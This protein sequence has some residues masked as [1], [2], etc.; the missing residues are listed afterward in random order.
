MSFS[1]A[2]S[3]VLFV[4]LTAEARQPFEPVSTAI[5]ILHYDVSI[6]VGQLQETH[7]DASVRIEMKA[8]RPVSMVELDLEPETITITRVSTASGAHLSHS[9]AAG[10]PNAHGLTGSRLI[11]TLAS[12]LD[13]GATTE[14][15]IA[16]LIAVQD[17]GEMRGFFYDA[18]HH[19]SR[20][21][22]TRNWPY[23]ARYWLPGNDHPSDAA[24]FRFTLR[25]PAG[26]SPLANG[27]LVNS[28]SAPGEEL[29][30]WEHDDPIPT[31]AVMVAFGDSRS[32]HDRLCFDPDTG[33][34]AGCSSETTEVPVDFFY[35]ESLAGR[36][37]Y[38]S[39]IAEAA[40]ALAYFSSRLGPWRYGKAGFVSVP[41]PFNMEAASLVVLIDPRAA[42]HETV[43]HW[44]GNNVRIRSW[45][46]FWIS[47]GL[48]T[49]FTGFYNEA[50]TGV[51]NACSITTGTLD[52]HAPQDP[53]DL[54]NNDAYCIGAAA[55]A[56]YRDRLAQWLERD[57]RDP[58]SV[59]AFLSVF[60][61]VYESLEGTAANTASFSSALSRATTSVLGDAG[62]PISHAEADGRVRAWESRWF[63]GVGSW[64]TGTPPRRR[65]VRH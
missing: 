62:V 8:I 54:F 37:Q 63:T 49:Y 24:T 3:I 6:S 12:P 1:R 35:P 2:L 42:V 36:S 53:L 25:G 20:V 32:V 58:E 61:A 45:G 30:V 10:Q 22:A 56:D 16:Y 29:R 40:D 18:D 9:V 57:P 60:R 52:V 41:H 50:R 7:L 39:E 65:S 43:H 46:D 59:S 11:I 13:A 47:E 51:N 17:D 28:G 64:S 4:A 23:F 31:Y 44:W 21:L 33:T 48:T 14:V 38:Q 15:D 19:G 55:I 5:D 26:T 27:I 34:R